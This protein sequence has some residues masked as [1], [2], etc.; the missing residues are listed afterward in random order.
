LSVGGYASGPITALAVAMRVPTAVIEPNAMPGL[1]NRV[2]GRVVTRAFVT[3]AET[4]RYFRH[5]ATRVFG[6]PVRRAFL[7]RV[8]AVRATRA[9]KLH[10]LVVGG[11]QGAQAI[12]R[13]MPAAVAYA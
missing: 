11:S 13:V 5:G 10:V 6:S 9:E 2:L 3:Y 4:E 12:N 1:T 8:R 7:D